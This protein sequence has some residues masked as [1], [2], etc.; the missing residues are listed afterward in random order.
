[1]GNCTDDGPLLAANTVKVKKPLPLRTAG[2]DPETPEMPEG[3]VP[4]VAVSPPLIGILKVTVRPTLPLE[5]LKMLTGLTATENATTGAVTLKLMVSVRVIEPDVAVTVTPCAP[6]TPTGAPTVI[7]AVPLAV[8]DAG[9]NDAVTP[10]V[11]EADK[12]TG[13][14]KPGLK[15]T[16]IVVV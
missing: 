4:A 11:P 7:T 2:L 5:A 3:R 16:V 14:V 15:V 1:M 9:A 8:K 13:P 6:A 12:F 10:P